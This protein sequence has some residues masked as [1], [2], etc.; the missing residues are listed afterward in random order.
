LSSKG[1][2][3]VVFSTYTDSTIG[4]DIIANSYKEGTSIILPALFSRVNSGTCGTTLTGNQLVPSVAST[5]ST[6]TPA[7]GN[8]N[9][10]YLFWDQNSKTLDF[11]KTTNALS[12]GNN[13][14]LRQALIKNNSE[15]T[16]YPNPTSN[17]ITFDYKLEENEK[18][19]EIEIFNIMGQ[20]IY[21]F[22]L[23]EESKGQKS[24]VTKIPSG[25]Y[26]AIL[27]TN[28]ND[29]KLEFIKK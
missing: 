20:S 11:K 9:S 7:G 15:F 22:L 5:I 12:P 18:A 8:A 10:N 27:K 14:A 28:A 19:S 25:T 13:V 24:D 4:F 6:Q 23:T 2:Y 1:I 17:E 3:N 21:K 29:Y 26:I 16:A